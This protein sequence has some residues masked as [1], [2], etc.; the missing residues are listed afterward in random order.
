MLRNIYGKDLFTSKVSPQTLKL[1][2][3][4]L[5]EVFTL[6]EKPQTYNLFRSEQYRWKIENGLRYYFGMT[7]GLQLV[8]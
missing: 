5:R 7:G 1:M 2:S 4:I 6:P 8:G 3:P